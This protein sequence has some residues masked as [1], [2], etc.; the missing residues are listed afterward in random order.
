M[1]Y[2]NIGSHLLVS[3]SHSPSRLMFCTKVKKNCSG[4]VGEPCQKPKIAV[5][6]A[7]VE[8]YFSRIGRV[9]PIQVRSQPT[10]Q[11]MLVIFMM[12]LKE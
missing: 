4:L 7:D 11:V 1:Y 9:V 3:P 6:D 8:A 2:I 5:Y 10:G 12:E